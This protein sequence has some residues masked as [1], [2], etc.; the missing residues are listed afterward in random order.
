MSGRP[1]DAGDG[2]E[3]KR[4]T[5]VQQIKTACCQSLAT[6]LFAQMML[7]DL[8][9]GGDAGT[10]AGA[11]AGGGGGGGGGLYGGG[12]GGEGAGGFG[13]CR[14]LAVRVAQELE[15]AAGAAHG[16]ATVH[17]IAPLLMGSDA[18][19]AASTVA[20]ELL[21]SAAGPFTKRCEHPSTR[22]TPSLLALDAS[23]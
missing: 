7:A 9:R 2:D 19:A 3:P 1:Y 5:A 12:G 23:L 15:A 13:R 17:R 22:F 4:D 20:Y 10:D 21:L 18:D 8:A 16:A 11:G 6:Y 14:A